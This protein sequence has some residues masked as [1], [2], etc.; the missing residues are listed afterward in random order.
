MTKR[1]LALN[2]IVLMS[3]VACKKDDDAMEEENRNCV[4]CEGSQLG[5]IEYCE[6]E[7]GTVSATIDGETSS[8]PLNGIS[9]DAYIT[10]LQST[11]Q[12]S[13]SE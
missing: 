7:D 8:I 3:L 9:F 4:T 12:I 10:G 13:C 2:L 11:G 5:T 1:F 6:N